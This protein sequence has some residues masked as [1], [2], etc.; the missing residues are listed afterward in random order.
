MKM[1]LSIVVLVLSAMNGWAGEV[2]DGLGLRAFLLNEGFCVYAKTNEICYLSFGSKPG[3]NAHQQVAIDPPDEF[4]QRFAGRHFEV[5]KASQYPES[6]RDW[7]AL[8]KNP[9]TGVPDGLYTAEI[10]EWIDDT[11]AKVKYTMYR[12]PLWAAG[13]EAVVE[14]KDGKWRIKKHGAQ[15]VS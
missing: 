6:N 2:R 5:R 1:I 3:T 9:K 10:V 7:K 15:W 4:L 11:T 13:Y 8:A 12:A 14:K